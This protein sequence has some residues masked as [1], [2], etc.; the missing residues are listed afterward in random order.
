MQKPKTEAVGGIKDDR[1]EKLRAAAASVRSTMSPEFRILS[2]D[3]IMA[4]LR[5]GSF[6][7]TQT[8]SN[9]KKLL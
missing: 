5:P 9:I 1:R 7:E 3:Q 6:T 8:I 4:I 2:S